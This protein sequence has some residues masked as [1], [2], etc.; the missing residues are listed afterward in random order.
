MRSLPGNVAA[1]FLAAD[2]FGRAIRPLPLT[3]GRGRI[4]VRVPC[5]DQQSDP[6]ERARPAV[7]SGLAYGTLCASMS[8]Q[9][10]MS[11][12]SHRSR[13]RRSTISCKSVVARRSISSRT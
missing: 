10:W 2:A 5:V 9:V 7:V 8:P 12:V 13:A 6:E 1:R 3:V 11:F 4:F